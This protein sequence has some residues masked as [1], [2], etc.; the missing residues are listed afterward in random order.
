MDTAKLFTN[1]KSQAVRLPKR[2]RFEGSEVYIKEVSG[3]VLL[4]PKDSTVWDVW[5]KN[6]SKYD[7][8]F[9]S[10]RGQPLQQQEREALKGVFD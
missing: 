5:E 6:L 1:G 9:M 4:L 8:P 10:E 7:T 2:Y 3:G